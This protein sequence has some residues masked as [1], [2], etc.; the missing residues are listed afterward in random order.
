MQQV[1]SWRSCAELAREYDW[2]TTDYGPRSQ[3]PGSV[4]SVVGMLL[5]SPIP[6]CYGHGSRHAMVYND[7]F[8]AILGDRH[9]EAWAQPALDT[10]AEVWGD[11][12]ITP[13]LD[14]VFSTG[15]PLL[16]DD[17]V[18]LLERAGD[19]VKLDDAFFVRGLSPVRDETG[20]V[21]GLLIV[22]VETTAGVTRVHTVAE[23]ASALASAVSGD[24]VVKVALRHSVGRLGVDTAT[25]CLPDKRAGGWRTTRRR[26]TDILSYDEERLP[27]IWTAVG[28]DSEDRIVRVAESGVASRSDE[29]RRLALPF[30]ASGVTGA[31]D[32]ELPRSTV[33]GSHS[34][35]LTACTDLVD[36]ALVRAQLYDA[37]RRTADL[38]QRTL[39]PQLL[40]Q[41]AGVS[42]AVRYEAATSGMA[43]GGDFYDVFE[44]PDGRLGMVIGDVVGR[45]VA[46]AT[47]MGQ[48]RAA[49]RGAA[50]ADADPD[51]VFRS[52]DTLVA[53][54]D[55]VW[56]MGA[57]AGSH[58]SDDPV[59]LGIDGELFVT[60]LYC[61]L[62]P[63]TGRTTIASAGHFPPV[64]MKAAG[65]SGTGPLERSAHFADLRVGPPLGLT[66]HRPRATTELEE[67]D[68]L[69]AFTDGLLERRDRDLKD[70]EMALLRAVST[71]VSH[72]PR[73]I[74]QRV[75]DQMV[76]M[77]SLDD[78]CAL[79][80][81]V[82]TNAVH[83]TASVV[84]PPLAVAVRRARTWVRGQLDQWEVDSQTTWTAVTGVSELV[85]NVLLHAATDARVTL[86]LGP[87][88]L[89]VTVAD[90]GI[91]GAPERMSGE[92]TATRGR[93]LALVA[94]MA[95][96]CGFE[97]SV[98]GST[99]WFEILVEQPE[100]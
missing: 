72:E 6:M 49:V 73:S 10:V 31:I 63:S 87:D 100:C 5:E 19:H 4:E 77:Q 94:E 74:C 18:L 76:G 92:L 12:G 67:G 30:G 48:V 34:A 2:A 53:N 37:E 23:L 9:P 8:A 59:P 93:G 75:L 70:G 14:K 17:S 3:W 71:A 99:A 57:G 60:M 79:V 7:G 41:P 51:V 32:F 22:V 80:A 24:D 28:A 89:L 43:A 15:E 81:L 58:R 95:H 35:V 26:K 66:G 84:V 61:L 52:L 25:V 91:R 82:R 96:S 29:G 21:L 20:D 38:L 44:L 13:A 86:D 40:P 50:M 45:G 88:R 97:R 65:K 42:L 11:Q 46:A 39:L 90:T 62:D 98:V 69:L 64:V 55:E 54:L 36:E 1:I 68:A 33:P 83:R 85:T 27:L 78:D 47:V 16:E 56:P